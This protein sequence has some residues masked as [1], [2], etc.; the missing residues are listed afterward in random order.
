MG[1]PRLPT[2]V[3]AFTVSITVRMDEALRKRLHKAC[4]DS[5]QS[6][7][8]LMVAALEEYLDRHFPK[9]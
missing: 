7:S 5:N 8:G 6:M 1:T 4:H 3:R 2:K 9:L